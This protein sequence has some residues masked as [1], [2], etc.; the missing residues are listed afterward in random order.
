M[1]KWKIRGSPAAMA[2]GREKKPDGDDK[3][4]IITVNVYNY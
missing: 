1:F 4:I 2:S 3:V